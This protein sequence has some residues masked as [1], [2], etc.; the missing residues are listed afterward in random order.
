MSLISTERVPTSRLKLS[1]TTVEFEPVD[2][3]LLTGEM[4]EVH[5]EPRAAHC[6]RG[7]WLAHLV[8]KPG[9]PLHRDLDGHDG[10]PRYYMKLENA[11]DEITEW[12]ADRES[13][14]YP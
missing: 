12:M 3:Y 7:R 4:C 9:T 6:D 8:P 11:I 1:D 13:R 5:L 2:A 14:Y 10:W